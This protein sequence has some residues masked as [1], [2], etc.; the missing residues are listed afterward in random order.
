MASRRFDHPASFVPLVH[1]V[2]EAVGCGARDEGEG[3]GAADGAWDA[4]GPLECGATLGVPVP[5]LARSTTATAEAVLSLRAVVARPGNRGGA[6]ALLRS[7][8]DGRFIARPPS[9]DATV[10]VALRAV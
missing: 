7:R 2:A 10:P 8:Y 1:E 5:Q 6:V 4:P 9:E 3:E